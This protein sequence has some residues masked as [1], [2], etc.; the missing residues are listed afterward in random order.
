[1]THRQD[2]LLSLCL[3]QKRRAIPVSAG[4][5]T[6]TDPPGGLLQDSRI[7]V[8]ACHNAVLIRTSSRN[9]ASRPALAGQGSDT[10]TKQRRSHF[11][12][13]GHE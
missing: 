5:P 3:R 9:S 7:R 11:H 12:F 8:A 13:R 1:M 4:R 2:S 6:P 10:Q